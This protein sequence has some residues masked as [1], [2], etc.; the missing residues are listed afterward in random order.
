[1]ASFNKVIL[2]GNL[3]RN[4][5]LRYTP[6]GAAVC[7]FG[8]A[9]NHR[10]V[11]SDGQERDETCFV[12]IS[13]WGKQGEACGRYLQKGAPLFVEGRLKLDQWDDRE[14][15]KKVSK[16]RVVADRTQFIG[17]PRGSAEQSYD[18]AQ[19]Q[20]QGGYQQAP[21]QA[22]P[23]PPAQRSYQGQGGGQQQAPRAPY[24]PPAGP[25]AYAPPAYQAPPRQAPPPQQ[26]YQEPPAMPAPE[27]FDNVESADDDIPF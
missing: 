20:P 11:T 14:T 21:P 1:M 3:T 8:L 7:E 19:P 23:P 25:P 13:V 27:V 12:D 22:M 6:G 10:Y 5:E 24:Q 16:M 17:A 26:A 15:G 18:Q 9:I 4:P 2:M